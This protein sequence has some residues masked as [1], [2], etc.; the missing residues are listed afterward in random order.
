[1]LMLA[2]LIALVG[3][4]AA[5]IAVIF[6]LPFSDILFMLPLQLAIAG[7][8][9]LVTGQPLSVA[10]TVRIVAAYSVVGAI[11]CAVLSNAVPLLGKF[12][13]APFALIWC[14]VLGEIMIAQKAN[15]TDTR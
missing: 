15:Q 3:A 10:R 12:V 2:R 4:L 13:G 11:I 6:P 1:M 8:V 7:A 5:A 14:Y 9:L